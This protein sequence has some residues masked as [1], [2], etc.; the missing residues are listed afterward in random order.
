MPETAR[1]AD[2]CPKRSCSTCSTAASRSL[3]AAQRHMAAFALQRHP[4]ARRRARQQARHAEPGARAD[5]RRWRQSGTAAAAAELPQLARCQ[6]RQRERERGEVVDDDAAARSRARP[7]VALIENDQWL[8]V[9]CTRSPV[10][11][12]A[13]PIAHHGGALRPVAAQVVRRSRRRRSAWSARRQRDDVLQRR[14]P[15]PACQAKR[16]FVPPMS[17][18]RRAGP[19][20]TSSTRPAMALSLRRSGRPAQPG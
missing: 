14:P 10:I 17:P 8:F 9:I 6:V 20:V 3:A 7:A 15:S 11:G 1:S 2:A 19:D 12:F 13:M 18:S 5:Q 16:A 4:G